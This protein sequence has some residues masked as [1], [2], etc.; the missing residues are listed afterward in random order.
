MSIIIFIL[1]LITGSFLN[2]VVYRSASGRP[3]SKGRSECPKCGKTLRWFELI[4]VLSFVFQK[5]K[6][7]R[8]KEKISWQ[9][10]AVELL[11]A[12][13][14]IFIWQFYL[15]SK[16]PSFQNKAIFF[17]FAA[18]LLCLSADMIAIFVYDL[19]HLEV[20]MSFL[21][22]GI[23]LSIFT[24][25]VR[26]AGWILSDGNIWQQGIVKV[27]LQSAL[28]SGILGAAAAGGFFLFLVLISKE[29]WMGQGDIYIGAI[30]GMMIGWPFILE[31]LIIAFVSGALIGIILMLFKGK[32]FSAKIAFGPF[33]VFSCF[34][35]L[36][37]GQQIF[38]WYVRI[39]S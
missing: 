38:N 16:I 12:G 36:L 23:L 28:F 2:V 22:W 18:L 32:K 15:K 24:V 9:Y 7:R 21:I 8:C 30:A 13:V 10:P 6:C 35:V 33:L 3:I 25:L 14:F 27:L 4:P 26:D 31:A 37:F 29:K 11:T 39:I 34:V 19:I 5:G 20:P 1:G 17:I